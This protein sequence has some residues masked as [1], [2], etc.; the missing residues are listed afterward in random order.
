[1]DGGGS[2]AKL[3]VEHRSI[4]RQHHVSPLSIPMILGWARCHFQR[5]GKFPTLRSGPL[6]DAP[7]E[8]WLIIDL[9]L[10]QGQRGLA[11]GSS[12]AKL[13]SEFLGVSNRANRPP[14]SVKK[15]LAWAD[16]YFGRHKR[17]PTR[18][19]GH[20]EGV[21]GET[22]RQIDKAFHRGTRKL[23]RDGSLA[24]CLAK[25]R[26]FRNKMKLPRLSIKQ[27]LAWAASHFRR[28]GAWPNL[29]S[30]PIAE[31]PS[32]TW[33]GINWSLTKGR[34]GLRG[35]MTLCRLICKHRGISP[36]PQTPLTERL[37]VRWARAY[38]GRMGKWPNSASGPIAEAP[39]R[40]WSAIDQA[41]R[42]GYSGLAGGSSLR[43]LL[44]RRR[45]PVRR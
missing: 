23:P 42:Q 21:P 4:R 3:L 9:A 12:L 18:N 35:R 32:E 37:I 29:K 17:W 45:P 44:S 24:Q 10:R 5:T 26:G 22:W 31:A 11:G 14:L 13:F 2:L 8:S 7:G 1:L 6:A 15:I 20:V 16:A 41:L 34:R 19:S 38:Y 33:D 25:H 40:T 43:K 39:G 36:R 27:I 28:T 30:G